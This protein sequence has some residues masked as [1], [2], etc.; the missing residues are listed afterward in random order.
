MRDVHETG[1]QVRFNMHGHFDV[2]ASAMAAA[3]SQPSSSPMRMKIGPHIVAD[4]I[5]RACDDKRGP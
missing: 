5:A 3:R 1:G 2:T 4:T